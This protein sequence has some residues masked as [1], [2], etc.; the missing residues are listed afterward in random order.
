MHATAVKLGYIVVGALVGAL[1]A[2]YVP[3]VVRGIEGT[4]PSISEQLD[5]ITR[6]ASGEGYGIAWER[7]IDGLHG[8]H[9]RSLVMILADKRNVESEPHHETRP[10]EVRIYDFV[11]QRGH[12]MLARRF[13]FRPRPS[14]EA[15]HLTQ[16][17]F[18]VRRIADVTH[19][20][21]KSIIGYFTENRADEATLRPV[22]IHWDY[23]TEQ[24]AMHALIR[25]PP[26]LRN[27]R[28][29]G[30]RTIGFT[31]EYHERETLRDP[32]SGL[33]ITT[34]PSSAFAVR[35]EAN[36]INTIA[37]YYLS[38]GGPGEPVVELADYRTSLFYT[39]SPSR[40]EEVAVWRLESPMTQ[41]SE[42]RIW[43]QARSRAFVVC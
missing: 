15:H 26:R 34:Y 14:V 31:H 27:Y 42:R 40:C 4:P 22:L 2:I 39:I 9:Q 21:D 1:A 24:Y 36:S 30:V 5:A 37:A 16:W 6:K 35:M 10:E 18:A 28:R 29:P 7:Y 11:K 23:H 33:A 8:V 25:E 41:L 38:V 12:S 19:E 13:R 3:R 43:Q 32:R 17:R 20:G